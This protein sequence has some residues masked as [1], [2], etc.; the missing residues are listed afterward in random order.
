MKN[1]ILKIILFVS[2]L[3]TSITIHAAGS[4]GEVKRIYPTRDTIYFRLK[5]DTCITGSQYYFFRFNES[6]NIGKYAAKNWYSMLLANAMS[7]KPVSV[8]VTSCPQEGH[9]EIDYLYQDY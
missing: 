3:S 9:V 7:S 1:Y 4:T 8:S 5:N 2:V 6:D